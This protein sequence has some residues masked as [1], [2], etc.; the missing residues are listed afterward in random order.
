MARASLAGAAS[1]EDGGAA[2][3]APGGAG[4]RG[5]Q[6]RCPPPIAPAPPVSQVGRGAHGWGGLRG[7]GHPTC[8]G[9]VQLRAPLGGGRLWPSQMGPAPGGRGVGGVSSKE[10]IFPVWVDASDAL[11]GGEDGDPTRR[12]GR[13]FPP[14]FKREAM[15]L[16]GSGGRPRTR[17]AAGLG[18]QPSTPRSWRAAR[19]GTSSRPSAGLATDGRAGRFARRSGLRE[20][21]AP[22][23]AHAHGARR[24]R[25]S[26]RHPRGGAEVR[27]APIEQHGVHPARLM[28][29][30]IEVSPGGHHAWRSRPE[31]PRAPRPQSR[32]APTHHPHPHQR[33]LAPSRRRAHVATRRIVGWAMRDHMRTGLAPS[34]PML[35]IQCRRPGRGLVHP[36]EGPRRAARRGRRRAVHG[37]RRRLPRHRA[38]GR[39]PPHPQGRERPPA[40]SG[41]PRRGTTRPVRARRTLMR[42]G[43]HPLG[44]RFKGCRGGV[45]QTRLVLDR[46]PTW[47]GR[48]TQHPPFGAPRPRPG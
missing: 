13:E 3:G 33:G 44:P 4:R 42:P 31:G 27:L 16:L 30:V 47:P 36:A 26:H 9:S 7:W 11:L 25:R 29:R 15:A 12:T 6:G 28:R 39:I 35:A 1:Q 38:H 8:A 19:N 5:A 22:A 41:H 17:I 23:R 46:G 20:R 14:E 43:S 45:G 21:Q 34:A 24:A 32:P 40:S 48:M 2:C 18:V 10:P 37:T